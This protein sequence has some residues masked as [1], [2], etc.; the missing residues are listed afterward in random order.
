[1]WMT[2]KHYLF[3]A[4]YAVL[5]KAK[6]TERILYL[7]GRKKWNCNLLLCCKFIFKLSEK[8]HGDK[9]RKEGTSGIGI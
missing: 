7:K 8:I 5:K 9:T 3:H 1:M 6:K 4:V 2:I